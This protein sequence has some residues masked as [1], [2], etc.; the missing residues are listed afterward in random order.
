[1]I[2]NLPTAL[3]NAALALSV[4]MSAAEDNPEAHIEL[5]RASDIVG[6]VILETRI[7]KYLITYYSLSDALTTV[8]ILATSRAEARKILFDDAKHQYCA[9]QIMNVEGP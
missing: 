2:N 1:M 3:T 5:M 8:E 6:A 7:R 9:A 4:A